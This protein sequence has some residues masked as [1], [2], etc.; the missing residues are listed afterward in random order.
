C[1][2]SATGW[3]EFFIRLDV[4]HDISARM[5]YKGQSLADAAAATIAAVGK[6]G[7]D[8]GVIGI[9][10][11]GNITMEFNSPGMYRA[12][13]ITGKAPVIAVYGDEPRR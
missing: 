1:A 10:R 3:G 4:A 5:D 11:Q 2:V 8:G 12:Y 6:L 13:H 9:D 7:G